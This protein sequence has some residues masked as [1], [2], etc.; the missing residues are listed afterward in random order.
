[1]K[2]QLINNFE[3]NRLSLAAQFGFRKGRTT[4]AFII[5]LVS[6]ILKS[7]EGKESVALILADLR[8]GFKCVF[9][10]IPLKNLK[11]YGVE[12]NVLQASSDA[13]PR[14]LPVKHGEPQGSVIGSAFF[15]VIINYL[16]LMGN[17]L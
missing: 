7:F 2:T 8:K 12:G 17:I 6:N 13:S 15:L 3:R 11:A 14:P 9:H 16:G 5:E 10:D 1:M 4:T